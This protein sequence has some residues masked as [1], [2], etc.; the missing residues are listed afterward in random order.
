MMKHFCVR[1][2]LGA[3]VL[4]LLPGCGS[5]K[6]YTVR[7]AQMREPKA[8]RLQAI[9]ASEHPAI[10]VELPKHCGWGQQVGTLWIEEAISGRSVWSLS[11]FMRSGSTHYFVPEGLHPGTYIVILRANGEPEAVAN[12]DVQ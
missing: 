7:E 9:P 8:P 2:L 10:V 11:E 1:M 12:F 5:V 6:I 3:V 4:A